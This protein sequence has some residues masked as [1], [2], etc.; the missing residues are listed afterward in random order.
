[1]LT[2]K[3]KVWA[4][5]VAS[6]AIFVVVVFGSLAL[7]PTYNYCVSNN[8]Q[9]Y[10][11]EHNQ[12]G[13]PVIEGPI[14]SPTPIR[15]FIFCGGLYANENGSGITALA[16]V[17]LTIVTGLLGWLAWDQG[18][19]ARAQLRAYVSVEGLTVKRSSKVLRLEIKL[20]NSGETPAIRPV[21]T[22]RTVFVPANEEPP[23]TFQ[24]LPTTLNSITIRRGGEATTFHEADLPDAMW[25]GF[26]NGSTYMWVLGTVTYFDVFGR[27]RTT[28]FKAH[29][30][31]LVD[32]IQYGFFFSEDG[33]ETT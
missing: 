22:L 23:V 25:D 11:G 9:H 8:G 18:H 27:K 16:T 31:G 5:C 30:E 32:L 28:D 20:L 19:T 29:T 12:E 26:K 4:F 13:S 10:T 6:L 7:S 2:D 15:L 14:D 1:M 24:K 17:L 33:N 3:Q 21:V